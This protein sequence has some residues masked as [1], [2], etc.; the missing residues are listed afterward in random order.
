MPPRSHYCC[1]VG[2]CRVL[3]AQGKGVHL[4]FV[5]WGL[6]SVARGGAVEAPCVPRFCSE[7]PSHFSPAPIPVITEQ[8]CLLP[9]TWFSSLK[10]E[11]FERI[12][13]HTPI[14]P[15]ALT[16]SLG[17]SNSLCGRRCLSA[18]CRAGV[19]SALAQ[20]GGAG[21]GHRLAHPSC[22]SQPSRGPEAFPRLGGE[23]DPVMGSLPPLRLRA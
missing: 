17:S 14:T 16:L 3:S 19:S 12:V 11:D 15:K 4:F 9:K 18:H 5:R 20:G 21:V 6:F 10:C 1:G 2:G 23:A 8:T 22:P 13:P 7:T